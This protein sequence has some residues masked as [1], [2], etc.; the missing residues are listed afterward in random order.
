MSYLEVAVTAPINH[1]LTYKALDDQ[2]QSLEPGLRLLVP[3][4][5]RQVTGYLLDQ[6]DTPP[7]SDYSLRTIRD[8]LDARPLFPK[9]MVEFYRWLAIYYQYPIGEI[10][11]GSL[12][13][14]L[15]P[16]SG[17][18]VTLTDRGV[19]YFVNLPDQEKPD[20][21][22]F[23]QLI[24]AGRLSFAATGRVW[25]TKGRRTLEKWE[26]AGLVQI[27]QEISGDK[28]KPKTEVCLC[29]KTEPPH[30]LK[31]KVSEKKTIDRLQNLAT[32]TNQE[33]VARADLARLY[34]GAR[35]ALPNLIEQ[36]LITMEERAVYRDPFGERPPFYPEPDQLTDEQHTALEQI[37]PAI[38][39]RTFAPFLLH[40][41]T[42]SGKTEV[43]LQAAAQTLQ[44]GR[45]VLVL[46]PEIALATQLEGNFL[47]RFGDQVAILHSGLTGGERYDQWQRI[48]AGTAKVVVGARSALFAPL[49]DPG[50]IIVDEE[51]DGAYKQEDGFRY[52]ARDCAVMRAK[53][54][55]AIVILGSA[56][57]SIVSYSH[58]ESSKYGLIRMTKRIEN[59]PMPEVEI[60]DLKSIATK[61]GKP[62][63][64]SPDLTKAVKDN[65][66]AGNQTLIFLNR[67]GYANLMLC[68]DCGNT[69]QCKECNITLTLHQSRRELNCHYCGFST[70]S[71]TVC[72]HCRSTDLLALGFGT[73]RLEEE[74]KKIVPQA[75]IARLDRDTTADRKNYINTLKAV[76]QQKIDILVGTQM[77][78]KGHHFPHV[79]LVGVVWAD[80]GLGIPDYK[81]GERTFQLLTQVFGRAGRGDKPGRVLVQ[82]YHPSHFS[83]QSAREHNYQDLYS[84][85]IGLRQTL[86][87]PPFSRLINIRIEGKEE[88]IVKKTAQ[89]LADEAIKLKHNSP[90]TAILGPAPAPLSKLRGQYR[91]QLLLKSNDLRALHDLGMKLISAKNPHAAPGTIK[92]SLDVDPENML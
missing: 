31:L 77:I 78:T 30:D 27:N 90:S 60:I 8:V 89:F 62:P 61:S 26:E 16:Q 39:A 10:I 92:L 80:A 65:F 54:N 3:L 59:R 76:H 83:I 74:L 9:A 53:Q 70:A 7:D 63:L 23:D 67:R 48:S 13:A 72:S 29:L 44:Q 24:S 71:A 14:G 68:R 55:Q 85:E 5:R 86:Y 46:V 43:Y 57:P 15:A 40:G 47:S 37:A 22:W 18:T 84:Q 51:H 56:T 73:E 38:K 32:E 36:G 35:R 91:W 58:A 1:T 81:A 49:N 25:R 4:G 6:T 75:R 87:Y 42:G 19:Q 79:T 11:K 52:Q 20:H 17:R 45:S 21:P 34:S 50:L 12:P 66:A 2:S 28:I 41:V 82:T 33:W 88:L 64:F 69:L